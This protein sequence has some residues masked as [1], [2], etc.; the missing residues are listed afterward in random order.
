MKNKALTMLE[1]VVVLIIILTVSSLGI[2]SFHG[3]FI[4]KQRG[5]EAVTALETI[6]NAEKRY[7]LDNDRYY[8]CPSCNHSAITNNLDVLVSFEHFNFSITGTA[9]SYTATATRRIGQCQGRTVT[10]TDASSN[11][12]KNCDLWR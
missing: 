5:L 6:Y 9:T 7:R 11:V 1:I 8:L 12:T 10:M 2:M 3:R 4:E